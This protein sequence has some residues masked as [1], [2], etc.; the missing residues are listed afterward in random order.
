MQVTTFGEIM[1]RLTTP[2]NDKLMQ[3][4]HFDANYGG[5][6]ANVAVS[7]AQLGD[8]V[9]YVTKLPEND[10]GNAAAAAVAKFGVD[11][12]KILRGGSRL[13]IYFLQRGNGIRPS[14]VIYDRAN[15]AF[16]ASKASDYDWKTLLAATSYFYISG[17]TPALSE[18][19][20]TAL[21]AAV[22]VC[23]QHQIPVV[24]DANYRGK[25]WSSADAIAFNEQIMPYVNICLVHD[26]DI[27]DA[28]GI[29]T[30]FNGDRSSVIDQK[31]SFE[32]SMSLITDMYPSV[33]TVGSIV[34]NIYSVQHGKWASLMLRDGQFYESPAY[35]INVDAEVASGDAFG[36]GMIH[37]FLHQFTPQDQ[38]NYAMA[39]AV[40]KLTIPGDFNLATDQEIRAIMAANENNMNR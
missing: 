32:D 29:E 13:G 20:Q 16:A 19:L 21:L 31:K 24:Y 22:K 25:L 12:T 40:L 10:L 8:Q 33:H 17:I 7:L 36:A 15:S 5:A 18:E 27:F 11:T 1:L 30:A 39:A 9:A 14:E 4:T 6:E 23:K 35:D 3:S 37:G 34:R 38:L 28:F 2:S 26:E